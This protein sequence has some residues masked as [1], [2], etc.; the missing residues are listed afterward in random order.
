MVPQV[1]GGGLPGPA[2]KAGGGKLE[3]VSSSAP[4]S[5][6]RGAKDWMD[7]PDSL[8]G[9]QSTHLPNGERRG[10]SSL[11]GL[12]PQLGRITDSLGGWGVGKASDPVSATTLSPCLRQQEAPDLFQWLCS[13]SLKLCCP[14]GT[15]GP[16]CLREFFKFLLG[17]WKGTAGA[18]GPVLALP[19]TDCVSSGCLDHL[20]GPPFSLAHRAGRMNRSVQNSSEKRHGVRPS[21]IWLWFLSCISHA[22]TSLGPFPGLR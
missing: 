1:S 22:W 7:D 11:V 16:T 18:R 15:F 14:S 9:L 8:S 2:G 13:D 5:K 21:Q 20:S 19:P 6:P 4:S 10:S 12:A 17:G 3:A